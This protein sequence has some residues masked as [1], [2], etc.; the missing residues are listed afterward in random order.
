MSIIRINCPELLSLYDTYQKT[1]GGFPTAV[2]SLGGEELGLALLQHYLRGQGRVANRLPG[3]PR[4]GNQ[5]GYRLDGWLV[6]DGELM[7]VEV[8]NWGANAIG[9]TPFKDG[10]DWAGGWQGFLRSFKQPNLQKVLS[11]M[12]PP[13]AHAGPVMHATACMWP[14][15]HPAGTTEPMFVVP[16]S[17]LSQVPWANPFAE[18]HVFSMSSYLRALN[19]DTL[20]LEMP[21]LHGR[22]Q[23]LTKIFTL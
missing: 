10:G 8:K 7:Q 20:D 3:V 6:L 17:D 19:V 13:L 21:V 18:L 5:K 2:S 22:L 11:P 9:G 1:D 12:R 23:R 4:T 14:V 16:V 15:M